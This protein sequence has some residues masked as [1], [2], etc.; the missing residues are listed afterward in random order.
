MAVLVLLLLCRE[1]RTATVQNSKWHTDNI[2]IRHRST[3]CGC[4]LPERKDF[5]PTVCS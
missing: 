1:T 2:C 3:I 5:G 4:L